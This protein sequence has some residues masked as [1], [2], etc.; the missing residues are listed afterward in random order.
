MG[1][2]KHPPN[3]G[4]NRYD[5]LVQGDGVVLRHPSSTNLY[6]LNYQGCATHN[7]IKDSKAK[8][9]APESGRASTVDTL[10]KI[11]KLRSNKG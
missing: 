4:I 3:A 8:P 6:A 1:R 7:E 2:L 11:S 9:S 10:W 5:L